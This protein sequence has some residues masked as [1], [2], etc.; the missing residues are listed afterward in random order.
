MTL[1]VLFH[2]IRRCVRCERC[3]TRFLA[4]PGEG[5]ARRGLLLLGEAPGKS[6]DESG[7]PFAGRT[8][9]YLDGVMADNGISRD[10]AFVTSILKCYH[11]GPPLPRQVEACRP[12]TVQQIHEVGPCK[13]LV[14]GVVA[15]G[16][17][18]GLKELG[19]KEITTEWEGIV[20]VVTCHP[21]AAMRFPNRDAQF[22]RDL[23]RV[24]LL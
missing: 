20:C 2:G 24:L 8:G 10:D 13:L 16:G 4:V 23:A 1:E 9:R 14:M 12:W 21:T 6:E 5:S 15:A 7:R 11:P 17:L 22:R 3:A 19:E 18:M